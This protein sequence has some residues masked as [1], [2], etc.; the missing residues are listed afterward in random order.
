M[1]INAETNT[2]ASIQCT[3]N[4]SEFSIVTRAQLNSTSLGH[5]AAANN[6]MDELQLL[7][8]QKRVRGAAHSV[9]VDFVD[10]E[11]LFSDIW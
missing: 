11:I 7:L 6:S 5:S 4:G 1:E 2:N 8:E 9:V 3:L 10:T